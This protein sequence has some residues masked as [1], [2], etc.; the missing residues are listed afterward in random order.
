MNGLLINPTINKGYLNAYSLWTC[1][2]LILVSAFLSVSLHQ[3]S[4]K[5]D[6]DPEQKGC[7]YTTQVFLPVLLPYDDIWTGFYYFPSI[8][9]LTLSFSSAN[10]KKTYLSN[11][12]KHQ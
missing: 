6:C 4:E 1:L 3:N 12:F 10:T 11:K 9:L 5:S 8:C 2:M 7:A